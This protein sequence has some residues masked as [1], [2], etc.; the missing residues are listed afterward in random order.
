M[1]FLKSFFPE[2]SF[3]N[4]PFLILHIKSLLQTNF[5]VISKFAEHLQHFSDI[6]RFFK[7]T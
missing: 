7:Q 1:G 3:L 2:K 6:D 4:F 5:Y